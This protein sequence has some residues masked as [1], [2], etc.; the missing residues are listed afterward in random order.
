LSDVLDL[1]RLLRLPSG[2]AEQLDSSVRPL[3]QEL[4]QKAQT[5]DA[6]QEE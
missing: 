1:I 6:L 4:W 3:Y 5:P 2:L